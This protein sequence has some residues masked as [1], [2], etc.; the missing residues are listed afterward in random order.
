MTRGEAGRAGVLSSRTTAI[1]SGPSVRWRGAG[2]ARGASLL[3]HSP[4]GRRSAGTRSSSSG[5]RR[6]ATRPASSGRR[7]RRASRP[8]L[9]LYRLDADAAARVLPRLRAC[10]AR[11]LRD[12]RSA[13]RD[14]ERD[15]LHRPARPD[16]VVARGD[17]R[18]RPHAARPGQGRDDHRLRDRRGPPRVRRPGRSRH[19]ERAG[20]AAAR[21]RPRDGGRVGGR[22]TRERR[23]HRRDLPAG[24]AAD[25]GT[26]RSGRARSSRRARS[27]PGCS[28]PPHGARV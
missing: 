24:A 8:T 25:R 12:P 7:G 3:V 21:R 26:R 16:R 19:A 9:R 28:P 17:R 15:R 2:S 13:R 23:R 14:V 11:A 27:S 1:A 20:A 4:G 5:R 10:R 6:R 18:R 22:G